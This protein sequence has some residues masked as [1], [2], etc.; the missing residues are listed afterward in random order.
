MP[1]FLVRKLRFKVKWLAQA[2]ASSEWGVRIWVSDSQTVELPLLSFYSTAS[3]PPAPSRVDLPL[4]HLEASARGVWGGGG[5]LEGTLSFLG[6]I[7]CSEHHQPAWNLSQFIIITGPGTQPQ[8]QMRLHFPTD[9]NEF[10]FR[11][12]NKAALLSPPRRCKLLI[13]SECIACLLGLHQK[14]LIWVKE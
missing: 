10:F 8:M 12:Q 11:H 2:N 1:I 14:I 9:T 5:H 6:W 4:L 3:P 7:W 13:W